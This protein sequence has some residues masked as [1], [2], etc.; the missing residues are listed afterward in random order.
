[1]TM[2][3]FIQTVSGF[4]IGG[5]NVRTNMTIKRTSDVMLMASP[6]LP[7]PNFDGGRR[8]LVRRRQIM[9]PIEQM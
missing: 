1:M 6:Y 2:F 9:Q 4:G 3:Q 5:K 7:T 8:L